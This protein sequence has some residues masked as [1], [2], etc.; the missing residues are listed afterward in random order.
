MAPA[1]WRACNG[2]MAAFFALAA[3]VQVNDPDA[4]LWVVVYTIPA[5]LT[6]L[7]GLNPQITG[8]VIWKSISAIHILFCMVWAVGLAYYLLHHTQQNILHEEEGRNPVGGR[9][10]LAIAIVI[11]LFP[12]IS[13]VYIYINKEMRSSW[14][15]HCKTVI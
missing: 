6:L 15:T 8:N 3:Y 11:T 2:L 12:F 7:V 4:E 14:P 10:Q 5:V 13:W 9:I 1:L